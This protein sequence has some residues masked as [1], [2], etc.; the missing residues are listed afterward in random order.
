[1]DSRCQIPHETTRNHLEAAE[2]YGANGGRVV[3]VFLNI[4]DP[5]DFKDRGQ[6]DSLNDAIENGDVNSPVYGEKP[7]AFNAGENVWNTIVDNTH[8]L[9]HNDVMNGVLNW[10]NESSYDGVFMSDSMR[11]VPEYQSFVAFNA[12][13]IKSATGNSGAFDSE[14]PNILYQS[15]WH[16]TPHRGIEQTGFKLN[17][18]GTGEGAQ[19]YG[20]GMYFAS[21]RE[22]AESYRETLG[23]RNAPPEVSDL[24]LRRNAIRGDVDAQRR[25]I[26][27]GG[28]WERRLA[29][30]TLW[31]VSITQK[32][33]EDG[34]VFKEDSAS[35]K[36]YARSKLKKLEAELAQVEERLA[37]V[38]SLIGQ[39]YQVEIPE[40]DDLLDYDKP[41]SEQPQKVRDAIEAIRRGLPREMGWMFDG[42]DGSVQGKQLYGLMGEVAA[43]LNPDGVDNIQQA[44][45]ELLLEHGIPGL[46]YLD[47][48]S[49][50]AG[51]GSH[52]Y[53]IWDEALLTPE[54]AQIRAYYQ[55]SQHT[56]AAYEARI[57]EL[58]AGGKANRVGARVLD[59]SDVLGLLGHA[60]KPVVLQESKVIAGRDSHPRMTAEHWKKIPEWLDNPV[61]VFKS[62]TES[63]RLVV[64]APETIG[65]S[66]V[67]IIMEPEPTASGGTRMSAHLLVNAYDRS[68]NTP[69]MRWINDGLLQYVDK[70]KFPA[71]FAQ[72]VG[73]QLPNTALQ[74]KQGMRKILTEK[75]LAGWRKTHSAQDPVFS[76]KEQDEGTTFRAPE[77]R[78]EQ[79]ELLAPNGAVS[80]LDE[81]QWHQV[82][83]PQ[84]KAWFGDWEHD[85]ENASKVVDENGEPLV[86]YHGTAQEDLSIFD[87]MQARQNAD[88][89]SFFF[90]TQK[91]EAEGY[92]DNVIAA[93][94]NIR[95]P[96]EKPDANMHE[97]KTVKLT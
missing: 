63:G 69:F 33:V 30:G 93:F 25:K 92:G 83:S 13:Q 95:N 45:S 34:W 90:S 54:A 57:D 65:G 28:Q 67:S 6:I 42:V 12:N 8:R 85:P 73:R 91:E 22:V 39:L 27:R 82:R 29:D 9:A 94:L 3:D 52:N 72:S 97:N 11:D 89:P 38:S 7:P 79:G 68:S 17:K 4:K 71:F 77:V 78:N 23:A 2:E 49:R 19:A 15:A 46:R 84:F 70:K 36:R 50:N 14:N 26:E 20:W 53:V 75:N 37:E 76:R 43:E 31:G 74:N 86:V 56:K 32:P 51:E 1:M 5:F 58:F 55:R 66:P 59:R 44:A 96:V 21:R 35:Q 64:I 10:I 24:V 87:L 80:N 48:M 88:I 60:D 16:G 62:D 40:D 18:I 81:R 47:G 61:A 41:L